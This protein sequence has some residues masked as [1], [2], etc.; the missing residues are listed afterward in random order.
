MNEWNFKET[1]WSIDRHMTTLKG[2]VCFG[3]E[4]NTHR[5]FEDDATW[6]RVVVALLGQKYSI[7]FKIVILND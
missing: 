4:Q 6:I 3:K 1:W 5:R 2:H 7:V